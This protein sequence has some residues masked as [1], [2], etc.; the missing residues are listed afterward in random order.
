MH[1]HALFFRNEEFS[2]P[3]KKESILSIILLPN[4]DIH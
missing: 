4:Y 1:D 2:Q 3:D